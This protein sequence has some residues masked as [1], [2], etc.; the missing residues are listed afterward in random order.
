MRVLYS[1]ELLVT[2][3]LISGLP[4]A[5]E[6]VAPSEGSSGYAPGEFAEFAPVGINYNFTPGSSGGV[7]GL[8]VSGVPFTDKNTVATKFGLTT[9]LIRNLFPE[10]ARQSFVSDNQV[11]I[12]GTFSGFSIPVGLNLMAYKDIAY[13]ATDSPVVLEG[14]PF[15]SSPGLSAGDYVESPY[16]VPRPTN[17]SA[18]LGPQNRLSAVWYGA[19][20]SPWQQNTVIT[21]HAIGALIATCLDP[22]SVKS[23]ASIAG[24]IRRMLPRLSSPAGHQASAWNTDCFVCLNDAVQSINLW[25]P[26]VK[27]ACTDMANPLCPIDIVAAQFTSCSGVDMIEP[28]IAPF[29]TYD[30]NSANLFQSMVATCIGT[31]TRGDDMQACVKYTIGMFGIS[32]MDA[33]CLSA[34]AYLLEATNYL[35]DKSDCEDNVLS[36]ACVKDLSTPLANFAAWAGFTPNNDYY[37]IYETGSPDAQSPSFS[38]SASFLPSIMASIL[39]AT[40]CMLVLT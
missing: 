15:H 40:I 31:A 37:Y 27:S 3:R 16:P 10:V 23:A 9:S 35:A 20:C 30:Y 14:T 32:H 21:Q 25:D 38:E 4:S 29:C 36:A 7:S 8:T 2:T 13:S 22:S 1:F 6:S 33:N 17:S 12:N 34:W 28:E 19:V 26:S 24:C 11:F 39:I 5:R 18:V